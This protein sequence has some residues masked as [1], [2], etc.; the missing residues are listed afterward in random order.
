MVLVSAI[1]AAI[2][3]FWFSYFAYR[4]I[5]GWRRTLFRSERSDDFFLVYRGA[6]ICGFRDFFT[7]NWPGRE[8]V[9]AIE[10]TVF[11]IFILYCAYQQICVWRGTLF[12]L[13]AIG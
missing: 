3:N 12:I 5:S 10:V 6:K 11:N 1:E 13:G 9:S 4:E 7:S 8:F 2:F